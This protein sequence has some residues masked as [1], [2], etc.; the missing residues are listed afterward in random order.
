MRLVPSS[1]LGPCSCL[2]TERDKTEGKTSLDFG[3]RVVGTMT[4]LDFTHANAPTYIKLTLCRTLK[5]RGVVK[6][7]CGPMAILLL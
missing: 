7:W 6:Y 3:I 1:A 5:L 2:W 4:I